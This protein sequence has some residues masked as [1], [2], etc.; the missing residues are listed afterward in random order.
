[1]S[2]GGVVLH[3]IPTVDQLN[4]PLIALLLPI[5]LAVVAALYLVRVPVPSPAGDDAHL[6]AARAAA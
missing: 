6:T 1:M 2:A 5:H 3:A 4:G